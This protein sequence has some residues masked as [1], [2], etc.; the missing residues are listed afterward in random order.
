MREAEIETERERERETTKK[1]TEGSPEEGAGW[2]WGRTPTDLEAQTEKH[3]TFL[4]LALLAAEVQ[5][6]LHRYTIVPRRKVNGAPRNEAIGEGA[7]R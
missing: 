2:G 5:P 1:G 3:D 6:L 4:V 7:L